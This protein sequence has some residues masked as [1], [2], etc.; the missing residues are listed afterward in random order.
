MLF[1]AG[2]EA[3]VEQFEAFYAESTGSE[4]DRALLAVLLDHARRSSDPKV[5]ARARP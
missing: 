2:A 5:R 3:T 4:H 1:D